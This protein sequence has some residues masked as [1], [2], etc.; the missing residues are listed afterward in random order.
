MLECIRYNQGD[1]LIINGKYYYIDSINNINNKDNEK[2][3]TDTYTTDTYKYKYKYTIYELIE[4]LQ[5]NKLYNKYFITYNGRLI[6][7]TTKFLYIN[8]NANKNANKNTI[9]N[10]S[11]I[12]HN[13]E[14]IEKQKGGGIIDM[15]M[16]I[17][18]IGQVF[19]KIG[20]FII[21]LLKF[22]FWFIKFVVWIVIDLLNPVTLLKDLYQTILIFV[23]SICRIPL[24]IIIELYKLG[25][26]TIGGWMQGFWGWDMTGLSKNDKNSKYF[27]S[28]N[29]IKGQKT[30]ITNKNTVPFSIILGTIVCPP[31]GVFMDMGTSGW[32]NI[33]VCCLLTLL[34]YLPGLCYALLIIYS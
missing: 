28:Y 16:A 7:N 11:N 29:R 21:W 33:L 14:I 25:I 13:I 31:M 1:K 30:Y 19:F 3:K 18:K 34:F 2:Y 17:I 24:D 6:P 23:V 32:L 10:T 22:V 15:F 27:K 8:K 20:D 9:K 5:N 12:I 26:N 4:Y